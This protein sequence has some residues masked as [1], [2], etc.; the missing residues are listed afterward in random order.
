[1]PGKYLTP[2][3]LRRALVAYDLAFDV[4]LGYPERYN[5][6]AGPTRQAVNAV[7]SRLVLL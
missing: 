6:T 3:A 7:G 4:W 5:S 2:E 1:M